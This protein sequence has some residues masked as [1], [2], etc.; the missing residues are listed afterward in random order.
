MGTHAQLGVKFSDGT[1][2]GCY[3]HY[4]GATISSRL[5]DFLKKNTTTGLVML[6]DRAQ[7]TGGI[8]SFHNRPIG[9]F[10]E[11]DSSPVSNF[12]T[13][14]EP[15]VIDETS[16]KSY[17]MGGCHYRYLVDYETGTV[18]AEVGH[19]NEVI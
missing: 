15:Y 9:G 14:S 3:V 1:I 12:L 13:D 6:I 7:K 17:N 16:W 10:K 19:N 4:D 8:R 2:S 18:R 11:G 5:T